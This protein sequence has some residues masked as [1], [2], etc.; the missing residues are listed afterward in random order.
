MLAVVFDA[1]KCR[2]LSQLEGRQ[3]LLQAESSNYVKFEE[4]RPDQLLTRRA[5]SNLIL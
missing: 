5:S 4:L 2:E 3:I 1:E